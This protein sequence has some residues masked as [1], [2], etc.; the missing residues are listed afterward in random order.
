MFEVY[1]AITDLLVHT[2]AFITL[3]VVRILDGNPLTFIVVGALTSLA[4][5]ANLSDIR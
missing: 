5:L 1:P 2:G 4:S 3:T